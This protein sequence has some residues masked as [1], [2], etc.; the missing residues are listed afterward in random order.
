MP[1]EHLVKAKLLYTG[2]SFK[3]ALM[4]V[5]H[6]VKNLYIIS[7]GLGLIKAEDAVVPYE[8]TTSSAAPNRVS[9]QIAFGGFSAED[10]WS[11]INRQFRGSAT[12]IAD[13]V[14]QN[15]ERMV[16]LC[17]SKE[18][19]KMVLEDLASLRA[20][21]CKNFRI[22]G[23]DLDELLPIHLFD[24]FMPY[25]RRMNSSQVAMP[26]SNIDFG[27]RA[28]L[29]YVSRVLPNNPTLAEQKQAI[30]DSLADV[31][32]TYVG[33]ENVSRRAT[34]E[35]VIDLIKEEWTALNGRKIMLLRILREKHQVKCSQQRFDKLYDVARSQIAEQP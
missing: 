15:P 5:N 24:Y 28:V 14:R 18:Y 27:I 12:P 30:L 32:E 20:E 4:A 13:V 25:D 33:A 8:L 19:L 22:I 6:D 26:G 21:E 10:W 9:K 23:N 34:D 29:H 2:R 31:A 35:E 1:Q 16:I 7:A 11:G 3:R 17:L